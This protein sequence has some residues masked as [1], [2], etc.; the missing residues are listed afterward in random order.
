MKRVNEVR[1]DSDHLKY[2]VID[3][4][5]KILFTV[6]SEFVKDIHYFANGQIVEEIQS[7]QAHFDIQGVD[8]KIIYDQYYQK[9]LEK[10]Q[11]KQ[12]QEYIRQKSQKRN[13]DPNWKTC[14]Q[15]ARILSH[16][17]LKKAAQK[18]IKDYIQ[19]QY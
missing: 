9:S 3:E 1:I 5:G 12:H 18:L 13:S 19:N 16:G 6:H 2:D 10:H 7:V 4:T 15:A 14:C 17:G 8:P 11:K